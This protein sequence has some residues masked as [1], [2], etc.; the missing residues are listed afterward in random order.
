[1]DKFDIY[2]EEEFFECEDVE[3]A[4]EETL[5]SLN[6]IDYNEPIGMDAD[7]YKGI[8]Y[9]CWKNYRRALRYLSK[10]IARDP[11][12]SKIL[13]NYGLANYR[14]KR[15]KSSL[16]A[17]K[18]CIKFDPGNYRGIYYLGM[19]TIRLG[20]LGDAEEIFSRLKEIK[21]YEGMADYGF[22]LIKWKK[23]EIEGAMKDFLSAI[24]KYDSW[25]VRRDFFSFLKE[26][27]EDEGKG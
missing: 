18:K 17:F 21:G 11:Y 10:A 8:L 13:L 5:K 15:W 6:K 26:V 12:N 23:G 25:E 20:N 14:L 3:K 16:S 27:E 4:I 2:R 1:M 24:N 7:I 19:A 22:A 9:H